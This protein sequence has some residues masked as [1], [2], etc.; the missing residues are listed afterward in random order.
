LIKI[1]KRNKKDRF[2]VG[3]KKKR[4]KVVFKKFNIFLKM[5]DTLHNSDFDSQEIEYDKQN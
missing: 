2:L 3:L 5:T 1:Y 4:K